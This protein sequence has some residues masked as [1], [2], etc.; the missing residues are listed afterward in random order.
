MA[1]C[2][3]RNGSKQNGHN[4]TLVLES[5]LSFL[6]FFAYSHHWHLGSLEFFLYSSGFVVV[7]ATGSI[8][9]SGQEI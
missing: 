4:Q 7:K 1:M 5:H 9:G 2:T 6:L 8:L 3:S